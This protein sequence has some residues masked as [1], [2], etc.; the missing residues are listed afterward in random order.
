MSTQPYGPHSPA[1]TVEVPNGLPPGSVPPSA[2]VVDRRW[3]AVCAPF[4]VCDLLAVSTAV[5]VGRMVGP[6]FEMPE[7]DPTWELVLQAGAAEV[8]GAWGLG[9]L[10]GSGVHPVSELRRLVSL[11]L[12]LALLTLVVGDDA[13]LPAR[14]AATALAVAIFAPMA[15]IGRAVVRRRLSTHEWWG[16]RA[17]VI[18]TEH[19]VATTKAAM[20]AYRRQGLIPVDAVAVDG[21]TT[22]APRDLLPRARDAARAHGAR[23]LVLAPDVAGFWPSLDFVAAAMAGPNVLL[24]TTL[25]GVASGL[26]RRAFPVLGYE[27][28]QARSEAAQWLPR[29]AKRLGDIAVALLVLTA[30]APLLLFL[31]LIV[32]LSSPGPIFYAQS[33]LGRGGRKIRVWKFRTMVLDA[34]R[35][36]AQVLASDPV[37]RREWEE[38]HKLRHDP[39]I[40]PVGGFMRRWSLDELPQ[41]WNVLVGD[42]SI[43]GPRPI[44]DGEIERYGPWFGYYTSMRPGL[45]GLWQVSGRD[46]TTYAERVRLDAVYAVSWSLWLDFAICMRTV[47]T[48]I[49]REG[50]H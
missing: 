38:R 4:A 47:L 42:M 10:P 43:V 3:L 39:R 16:E 30:L 20:L 32:R 2:R 41:L 27:G 15:W 31:V 21:R 7:V 44:V 33:R 46:D 25:P 35:R 12:L 36:L 23:W 48:L 11:G 1:D 6:V 26:Q 50:A 5:T 22:Q 8:V 19:S 29:A 49:R 34:D 17:V 28:R 13:T 40:T 18:G 24:L 14:I 45:T 37:V 9:L